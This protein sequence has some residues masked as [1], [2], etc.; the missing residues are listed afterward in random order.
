[1]GEEIHIVILLWK[2]GY[3]VCIPF[4]SVKQVIV[5]HW[6]PY[7]AFIETDVCAGDGVAD[8]PTEPSRIADPLYIVQ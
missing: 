7:F 8:L 2:S 5:G 1:M 4:H 6:I 3:W